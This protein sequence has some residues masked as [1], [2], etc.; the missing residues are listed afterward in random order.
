MCER[1]IFTRSK[2]LEL[3]DILDEKVQGDELF[4]AVLEPADI[5]KNIMCQLDGGDIFEDEF[6]T[7]L[8]TQLLDIKEPEQKNE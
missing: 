1:F 8:Y 7:K 2:L 6:Q 4:V 3:A 5:T